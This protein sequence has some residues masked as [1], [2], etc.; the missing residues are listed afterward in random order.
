MNTQ[1]TQQKYFD[2]VLYTRCVLNEIK[3][4]TPPLEK[5]ISTAPLKPVFY[6]QRKVK[7][8]IPQL[9]CW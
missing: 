2:S 9:I 4:V 8:L 1:S 3:I 7:S 5:G 6:Q